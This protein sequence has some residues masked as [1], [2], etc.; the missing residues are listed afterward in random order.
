MYVLNSTE[1]SS[2]REVRLESYPAHLMGSARETDP[3][4]SCHHLDRR[5]VEKRVPGVG[6]E[7]TRPFLIRGV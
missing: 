3:R 6:F 7:P 1:S 2:A 5:I 4:G